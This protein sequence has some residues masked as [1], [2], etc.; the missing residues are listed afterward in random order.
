MNI[1]G[2]MKAPKRLERILRMDGI[3]NGYRFWQRVDSVVGL[4][5]TMKEVAVGAGLNYDLVKVQRS[6]NRI[7]K[8]QDACKLAKYLGVTTEWL[9]TGEGQKM[10]I[11]QEQSNFTD[12]MKL[13]GILDK[14]IKSEQAAM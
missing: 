11:P 10:V 4:D 2:T 9:V 3:E 12:I 7:P 1:G 14:L 5:R 6:Y 13:A 8:A